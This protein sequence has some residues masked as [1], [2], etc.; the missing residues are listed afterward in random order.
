[1]SRKQGE[2]Q[3]RAN[4]GEVQRLLLKSRKGL[5]NKY[6]VPDTIPDTPQVK[7][8]PEEVEAILKKHGGG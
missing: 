3:F 7:A 4:L 5:V 6:G 2:D 1:L 8:S